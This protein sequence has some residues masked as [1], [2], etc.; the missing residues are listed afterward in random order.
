[1]EPGVTK[2]FSVDVVTSTTSVDMD[3]TLREDGKL[4]GRKLGESDKE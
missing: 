2:T 3:G 4:G 1:M